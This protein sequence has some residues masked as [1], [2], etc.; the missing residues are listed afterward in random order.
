MD[1]KPFMGMMIPILGIFAGII[2]IW[3]NHQRKM[4]QM[5]LDAQLKMSGAASTAGDISTELQ[6]A[7]KGEFERLRQENAQLRDKLETIE[8]RM[9]TSLTSE[10]QAE[11]AKQKALEQRI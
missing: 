2:A 3:T 1:L 9:N 5:D 6:Q 11:I 4:R 7:I 10:V 8:Q